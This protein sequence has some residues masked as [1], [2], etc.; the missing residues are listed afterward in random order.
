MEYLASFRTW[1][2]VDKYLSLECIREFE[3]E[4]SFWLEVNASLRGGYFTMTY[5]IPLSTCILALNLADIINGAGKG[6]TI[7]QSTVQLVM[8]LIVDVAKITCD[9]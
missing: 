4:L 8:H 2:S 9:L 7:R 6:M 1:L 5:P 3:Q